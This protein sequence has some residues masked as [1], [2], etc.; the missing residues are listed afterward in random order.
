MPRPASCF[1][2]AFTSAMAAA[3]PA[4]S[5][6]LQC[7]AN[8]TDSTGVIQYYTTVANVGVIKPQR[9]PHFKQALAAYV[10]VVNPQSWLPE[11]DVVDDP[12]RP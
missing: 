11:G 7:R 1:L 10:I 4:A 5:A 2:V 9:L 8:A 12:S 6:W 3:G